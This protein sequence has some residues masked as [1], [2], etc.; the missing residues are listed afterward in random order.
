[1]NIE[2]SL[3]LALEAEKHSHRKDN[4]YFIAKIDLI[5]EWMESVGYNQ[6]EIDKLMDQ[7]ELQQRAPFTTEDAQALADHIDSLETS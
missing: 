4:E 2:D 5:Q 1:M 7:I 6:Y 3:R